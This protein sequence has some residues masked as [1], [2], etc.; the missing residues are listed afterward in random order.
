M[1]PKKR[2]L[3][4][5]CIHKEYVV[6]LLIRSDDEKQHYGMNKSMCRLLSSQTMKHHGFVT[7][8]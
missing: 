8:I 3:D 2:E 7:I 5:A 6:D 1:G 4:K